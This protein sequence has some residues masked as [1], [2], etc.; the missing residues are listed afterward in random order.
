MTPG[1]Y[2]GLAERFPA[3]KNAAV[4]YG[5]AVEIH[6]PCPLLAEDGSCTAYEFRARVCRMFPVVVTGKDASGEFEMAPSAHCPRHATVTAEDVDAAIALRFEYNA[7][8]AASWEA[9]RA[10]HPGAMQDAVNFLASRQ[11]GAEPDPVDGAGPDSTGDRSGDEDGA[12]DTLESIVSV[13]EDSLDRYHN[14]KRRA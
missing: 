13:Y 9:Y 4:D 1:E 12:R 11:P 6:G 5:F 7:E 14:S 2:L 10:T 8:M 3:I